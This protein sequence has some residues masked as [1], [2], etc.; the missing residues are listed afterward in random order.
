MKP[1]ESRMHARMVRWRIENLS[2]RPGA[3]F[4]VICALSVEGAIVDPGKL[5]RS[6]AF[7]AAHLDA[8]GAELGPVVFEGAWT[9]LRSNEKTPTSWVAGSD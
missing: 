1:I 5:D 9:D 3:Y 8:I 7:E 4:P 6:V 2:L